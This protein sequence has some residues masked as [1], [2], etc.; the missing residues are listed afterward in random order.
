MNEE[1][2]SQSQYNIKDFNWF[3]FHFPV[4]TENIKTTSKMEEAEPF[5]KR[6]F[7]EFIL[8]HSWKKK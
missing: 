6:F 3:Q 1:Q 8:R 5:T 4:T 7:L 2:E